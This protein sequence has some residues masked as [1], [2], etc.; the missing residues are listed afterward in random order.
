M[1]TI[2]ST[3]PIPAATR[4]RTITVCWS[5][6][7]VPCEGR[8]GRGGS[9]PGRAT[10]GCGA[11]ALLERLGAGGFGVVWRARDELLGREVALKRIALGDGDCERATR[12]ALAAAR[13]A[14]PAIVALYEASPAPDAFYLISEL[15]RGQTLARL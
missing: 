6:A 4:R 10:A 9:D 14:H 8:R 11:A 13:L 5:S 12:E 7:S 3:T 1:V 2:S 15:V